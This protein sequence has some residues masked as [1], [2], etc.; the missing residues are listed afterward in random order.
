MYE[1]INTSVPNGLIAGTHGF[2][3]VAMTK[4]MPDAIRRRVE[5][6]CAYPHRTS[7][8]DA[9]YF[10][11]NP[12]NWF[13]LLLPGGD[14]VVGRTAPAD[15]DYTGR[16]NRLAHTLYF[17]PGEMPTAGGASVLLEE[18]SR[19]CAGWSG[20]PKFLP[21]DKATPGR[22]RMVDRPNGAEPKHWIRMFGQ[23]GL[24]YAKK[25][26]ALLAQNI[27]TNRGIYF[28]A[29]K[30]DADGKRLLG[31][32]SDLINLL[33][34]SIAAQV[35]FATFAPCVP[36]G[37]SCHLRGVYGKDSAFESAAS[38][39][40]W[41]DCE[42]CCVRH[43]ELLPQEDAVVATSGSVAAKTPMRGD[44]GGALQSDKSVQRYAPISSR[45]ASGTSQPASRKR[46]TLRI[47][48]GACLAL[49][50]IGAVVYVCKPRK[51]RSAADEQYS[52]ER[53]RQERLEKWYCNQTNEI[54]GYR[55]DLSDCETSSAVEK[56]EKLV[57][58]K[59]EGLESTW[60][61]EISG[62]AN[63]EGK[64]KDAQDGY[65]KLIDEI[66]LKLKKLKDEE[67]ATETKWKE[68][69]DRRKKSKEEETRR[70][71]KAEEVAKKEVA[72]LIEKQNEKSLKELQITKVIPDSSTW[73]DEISNADKARLQ[74][75]GSIRFFFLENGIITNKPGC[76]NAVV[77]KDS[78]TKKET[79]SYKIVQ[80]EMASARWCVI[81]IPSLQKVYWQW[82]KSE[83]ATLF[84]TSDTVDLVQILFGGTNEAFEVY[85]Q[86]V[87]D[88]VYVVSWGKRNEEWRHFESSPQLS[89][90]CFKPNWEKLNGKIK[91][92]EEKIRSLQED[93]I[94]SKTN[95]IERAR[96]LLK[97][98]DD[99]CERMKKH[100]DDYAKLKKDMKDADKNKK[101]MLK[102]EMEKLE[103]GAYE[104]F[105]K[106][107]TFKKKFN[108][109]NKRRDKDKV[110]YVELQSITP[111]ECEGAVTEYKE[112]TQ[113]TILDLENELNNL[114][115]ELKTA[116]DQ[117][118]GKESDRDKCKGCAYKV[119]AIEKVPNYVLDDLPE[120][121]KNTF[122]DRGKICHTVK[123]PRGI[124][125]KNEE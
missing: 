76:V 10:S 72:A 31:L 23:N 106:C 77:K 2:A 105:S 66:S 109:K 47:V 49:V 85:Q 24:A 7:A 25:F 94:P 22:L 34:K 41:V 58:S 19:F 44:F 32:F 46:S 26:A 35:S 83:K 53:I 70:K 123:W 103:N 86:K 54:V 33:P 28:K 61:D 89:I 59:Y 39:Q 9:T 73:E 80:P 95:A 30:E 3:T 5:N 101:K 110:F 93:K 122:L 12:V 125:S 43:A 52:L 36:N 79:T 50:V 16:T 45:G 104:V 82:R 37:V 56:L 55:R 113:R 40:P 81:E 98:S 108:G 27:R 114:K 69:G 88:I 107:E 14:H 4:G 92:L 102:G 29:A 117:K 120:D 1:L 87:V 91:N 71:C 57:H 13:H 60:E 115:K 15:F 65:K 121:E 42:N 20:E 48:V 75:P 6:F 8:H 97:D 112:S 116:Q 99:W 38:L 90:E 111:K 96:K 21:A 68:E 62:V 100:L 18:A 51:V 63:D 78:R 124:G 64:L 74:S 17:P 11:E 119:D 84:A 67:I 118:K